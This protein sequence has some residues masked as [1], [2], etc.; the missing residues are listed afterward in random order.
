MRSEVFPACGET[1]LPGS[2]AAYIWGDL[3]AGQ[4]QVCAKQQQQEHAFQ[5]CFNPLL[6]QLPYV[7]MRP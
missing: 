7:C 5:Q 4:Q 3:S 6:L 1:C 2:K